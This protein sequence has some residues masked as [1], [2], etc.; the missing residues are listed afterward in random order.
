M[1]R[2]RLLSL[3]CTM[4]ILALLRGVQA[5][6]DGGAI[7]LVPGSPMPNRFR[8]AN[9]VT[10][11]NARAAIAQLAYAQIWCGAGTIVHLGNV[12]LLIHGNT[13]TH[14]YLE[15]QL[16]GVGEQGALAAALIDDRLAQAPTPRRRE[17]VERKA[18]EALLRSL[19]GGRIVS[20]HDAAA[21]GETPETAAAAAVVT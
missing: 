13:G 20:A 21:T 14:Q 1:S 12:R 19:A 8:G 15:V 5:S 4:E 6:D 11:R 9:A 7:E 2:T 17:V 18:Q 16:N 10:L 3:I